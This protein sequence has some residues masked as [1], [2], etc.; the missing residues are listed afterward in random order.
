[1]NFEGL[2]I[3]PDALSSE[4]FTPGRE[5]T[6]K[7]D[8]IAGARRFGFIPYPVQSFD[9]L[10]SVLEEG[11]PVLVLVNLSLPIYP[12]WHYAVVYGYKE[13]HYLLRSG[14]TR[15]EKISQYT[16][17][18]LWERSDYWGLVLQAPAQNVPDFATP[19]DWLNAAMGLERV[20]SDDALQAYSSGLAKW[21]ENKQFA[22]ALGNSFYN[23]NQKQLAAK[24]LSKAVELDPEF[25]DA[26][27]NLA[28]VQLELGQSEQALEAI[29][30]A[31]EI[32]GPRLALYKQNEQKIKAQM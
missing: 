29:D 27:N 18:N 24:F 22:F 28:Q 9:D 32:G 30:R 25:A 8:L 17:K 11:K 31:I 4:V 23:K 1:L 26:W 10:H 14:Q 20:N 13:G 7:T 15:E 12:Q 21:P 19:K 16:F 6:L 5:G 2:E 3:Q